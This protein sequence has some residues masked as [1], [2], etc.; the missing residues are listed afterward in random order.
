MINVYF[1]LK[2]F[3]LIFYD[4]KNKNEQIFEM[5]IKEMSI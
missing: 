5:K 1:I 3:K 4:F 2:P